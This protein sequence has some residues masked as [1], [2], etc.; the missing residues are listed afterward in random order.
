MIPAS[1][2]LPRFGT[3]GCDSVRI[4]NR[5][6]RPIGELR[7]E[8]SPSP[9]VLADNIRKTLLQAVKLLPYNNIKWIAG[10]QPSNYPI[11]GAYSFQQYSSFANFYALWII[12][13]PFRF[14]LWRIKKCNHASDQ[15]RPIGDYRIKEYGFSTALLLVGW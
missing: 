3:V 15:I 8:P 2:F 7:P 9:L 13:W 4:P 10:S 14:F 11:V 5:Q 1:Q 12:I 6:Q